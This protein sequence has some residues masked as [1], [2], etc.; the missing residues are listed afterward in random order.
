MK[1]RGL[2]VVS[3]SVSVALFLPSCSK[4]DADY[5][6]LVSRNIQCPA[7]SR[8]EFLPWGQSGTR[9][10][11]IVENGP[12]AI[13]E[14][15]YLRIEGQYAAGKEVGEWRWFDSTGKVVRTEQRGKR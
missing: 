4:R 10:T 2:M 14:D 13:A 15:G 9:A 1:T 7:G 6:V 5:E 8:L 12:V 11:C 3:A